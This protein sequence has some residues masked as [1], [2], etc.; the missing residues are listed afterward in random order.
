MQVHV[1]FRLF[2]NCSGLHQPVTSESILVSCDGRVG[3]ISC[4]DVIFV[5]V[6]KETLKMPVK[7]AHQ[8]LSCLELIHASVTTQQLSITALR[9]KPTSGLVLITAFVTRT[10][11][12]QIREI[13]IVLD[14]N[15]K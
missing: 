5:Q 9:L 11:K 3:V 2:T 15:V 7:I 8:S 6:E 10:S 1:W 4:I 13:T 14:V 12:L